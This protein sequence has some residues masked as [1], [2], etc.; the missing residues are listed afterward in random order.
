MLFSIVAAL[1]YI[2]PTLYKWPPAPPQ[3]KSSVVFVICFLIVG[4]M[5]E[6][7]WNINVSFDLHFPNV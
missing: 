4:T 5:T 1:I 2:I 7:R 6:V 3:K